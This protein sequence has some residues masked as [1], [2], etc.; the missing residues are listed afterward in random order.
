MPPDKRKPPGGLGRLS[1]NV[2]VAD[3]LD[4]YR[5]NLL[6]PKKQPGPADFADLRFRRDVARLPKIDTYVE[7]GAVV[8]DAAGGDGF[9]Q[10][11]LHGVER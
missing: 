8:L 2:V 4:I 11:P 6:S 9:R 5:D 7:L 10:P 3:G 1:G